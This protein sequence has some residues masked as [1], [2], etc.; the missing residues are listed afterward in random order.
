MSLFFMNVAFVIQV[1]ITVAA[2]SSFEALG[3]VQIQYLNISLPPHRKHCYLCK[4]E[5][6]NTA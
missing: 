1:K 3:S 2:W 6:V 4:Y 5:F